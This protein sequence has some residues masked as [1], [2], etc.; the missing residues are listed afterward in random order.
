M[1]Y[2]RMGAL[3]LLLSGSAAMA[4][5][6]EYQVSLG[7]VARTN[8]TQLIAVGRGVVKVSYDG[9]QLSIDGTFGGFRF[10]PLALRI[11]VGSPLGS[12]DFGRFTP[13][14][15]VGGIF[16]VLSFNGFTR[17]ALVG[18]WCRR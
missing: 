10:G 2:A 18:D 11:L 6:E 1:S 4:A 14:F 12:F 16:P 13:H 15:L 8:A 7:P 5:T 3:V 9:K 17:R